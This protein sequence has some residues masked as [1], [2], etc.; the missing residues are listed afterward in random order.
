MGS[1]STGR[2]RAGP[3]PLLLGLASALCLPGAAQAG[4]LARSLDNL[5][6]HQDPLGGGFAAGPGTEA[7]YTQWAALAV[8]AAGEDARR[9]RRGRTSLRQALA[10]S[11]EGGSIADVERATVA[12]RAVGSD[13]RRVGGRNLVREVLRAQD[14]DGMIGPDTATT[15]WGILALRAAGLGPGSRS[16]H[17]AA[18]A[19]ER[20]QRKDGGWAL[21]AADPRSGPNATAAAIQALVAAGRDPETSAALRQARLFLLS[22]QNS[23]G[24]FPPVV[25]G[26]SAALTTAWVAISIRSMG[27][28]PNDVPWDRG[29]G[30]LEF[31]RGLQSPDGGVR[32]SA[33]SSETSVWAT[34]QAALAFSG[35]YL[36]H[37]RRI[38]RRVP[39]RA[40]WVVA[41]PPLKG[42]RLVIR[43]RDDAGGT[44]VDPRAVRVRVGGRDLTARA[45]VTPSHLLLPRGL[46]PPG[47]P[48]IHLS[49]ADRAGNGRA[50]RWRLD[51]AGR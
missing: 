32:N 40:P 43:Y 16:T 38:G 31:L 5:A 37:R 35:K 21:T 10:R 27:E 22:A 7:S 18:L 39:L 23:D 45:V 29:G 51:R 15:A 19:L 8:A 14:G 3:L 2:G 30:P 9:W 42:G 1:R 24:G 25:G 44:G 6:A 33:E 49:L 28:R 17:D 48:V 50:V 12:L 20:T 41:R 46:V 36:P 34:S 26:P 11:V 47:R 13:P 4:P